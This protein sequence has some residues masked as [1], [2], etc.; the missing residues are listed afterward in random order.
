MKWL[1]SSFRDLNIDCLKYIL[2][3]G[4]NCISFSPSMSTLSFEEIS[5]FGTVELEIAFECGED[6]IRCGN[7][8]LAFT[9]LPSIWAY[10]ANPKEKSA[11]ARR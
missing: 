9:T 10:S 7:V 1:S 11:N 4:F 8:N 5:P 3:L 6:L 2:S